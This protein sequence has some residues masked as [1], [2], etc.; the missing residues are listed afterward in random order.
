M[1]IN[2]P[3]LYDQALA[4]LYEPD[5]IMVVDVETTGLDPY[6]AGHR[7]CGIVIGYRGKRYYFPFRHGEG[8]NLP[9]SYLEELGKVLHREGTTYVGWNYSFDL[10]MLLADGI[11]LPGKIEDYM[12]GAHLMNENE[13]L[14]SPQ[15]KMMFRDGKPITSH[16]LKPLGDKYLGEGSS[17]EETRLVDLIMEKGYTSSRKRAKGEMWRLSA[18]QVAPYALDDV[19]LTAEL[20][21][22]YIPHLKTWKLWNI[23][24]EVNEYSLINTRAEIRGIQVDPD[25]IRTYMA[26]A[27]EKAKEIQEKV[28]QVAGYDI[29]L[30][31]PK[32]ICAMLGLSSSNRETL[33]DLIER[34]Q[35]PRSEVAEQILEYRQWSKISSTYYQKYLDVMDSDHRIHTN[36]HLTGTVSGRLSSSNPNLQAIP[37]RTEIY[38]VKDV[39]TA[40][41]GY[42]L[43]EADYSQAEMRIA[44][45]YSKD[46][47]MAERILRGADLHTETAEDLGIPR[48][49]SKRIN[50]GVIYG[51]GK[52]SLAKQ[53]K[54][55]EN[56]AQDYLAKYHKLYPGFRVLSRKTQAM[57]EQR[58]YIR[59]WT[60]RVRRYD[61]HN[62]SHKSM[63]NLIQGGVAELMRVKITELVRAL[64]E[65]HFVLQVHDSILMY[66]R[67]D[68]LQKSLRIMKQVL[69]DTV[70]DIPMK[71]DI[72][73]GDRWGT[74]QEWEEE[75]NNSNDRLESEE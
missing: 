23:F 50:F 70:F 5:P 56:V 42:Y 3:I 28:S 40:P 10:Q 13:Y 74:T 31:S 69:E 34:N 32:Q 65:A 59:M 8:Y 6:R 20:R 39:F 9:L 16:A 35:G 17:L 7:I 18:E 12:L 44:T 2:S 63:S 46:E 71:V 33:T 21:D 25:L 36:M 48:D 75:E 27:D 29:N 11:P 26:E 58:G 43:V 64:P 68:Q 47:L 54:I 57:A 52:V 24:E 62:P 15:G 19:R 37:R 53:L 30:N 14:L 55:P 66:I 67:K 73:Y 41:E 60:G 51:I 1:L 4:E 72:R 49:A 22:F 61:Q 38:K 45:D